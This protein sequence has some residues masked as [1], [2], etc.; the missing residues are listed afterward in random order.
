MPA[1]DHNLLIGKVLA[2]AGAAHESR[3]R[4]NK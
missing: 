2:R 1:E 4:D 3:F